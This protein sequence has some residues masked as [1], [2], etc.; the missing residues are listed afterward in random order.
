MFISRIVFFVQLLF[1]LSAFTAFLLTPTDFQTLGILFYSVTIGMA[2]ALFA[3]WQFIRHP[4][5]R[6]WALATLAT[7]VICLTTPFLIV[8][9]VGGPVAPAGLVVAVLAL[10]AIVS[11]VLLSRKRLWQAGS[12]FASRRFNIGF[13]IVL[14]ALLAL[15]WVP[16]ANWA[17]TQDSMTL[18][19]DIKERDRLFRL[20]L[21]FFV[22]VAGPALMLSLFTLLYA[23]I[24]LV[25]GSGGRVIHFGQLLLAVIALASLGAGAFVVGIAMVNPG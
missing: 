8:G 17:S 20:G 22:T 4:A 15:Y 2:A 7:P 24:G 14:F 5:R 19:N 6:K 1:T 25:R 10:V 13:V 16:I 18:P 23:P 3:L 21:Y 9:L 12:L 11:L